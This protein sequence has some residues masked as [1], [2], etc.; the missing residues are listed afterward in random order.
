MVGMAAYS[1]YATG[2]IL[3]VPVRLCDPTKRERLPTKTRNSGTFVTETRSPDLTLRVY[4]FRKS[5][6]AGSDT[7]DAIYELFKQYPGLSGAIGVEKGMAFV[8]LVTRPKGCRSWDPGE[9]PDGSITQECRRISWKCGGYPRRVCAG[10]L[11][12]FSEC[13]LATGC[14]PRLS[15]S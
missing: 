14:R 7:F 11:E 3:A 1:T 8:R 5:L 12:C 9:P 10:L 13:Y 4:G 15:W 2:S 6:M